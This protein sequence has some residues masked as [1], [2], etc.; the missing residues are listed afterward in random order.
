MS[1]TDNQKTKRENNFL[2]IV[3]FILE[4]LILN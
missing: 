3:E 1:L 2:L 4:V